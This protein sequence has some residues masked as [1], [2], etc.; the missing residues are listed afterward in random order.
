MSF[1]Y[2][3]VLVFKLPNTRFIM[4]NLDTT[5]YGAIGILLSILQLWR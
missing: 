3:I 5:I 1:K 4:A 2:S